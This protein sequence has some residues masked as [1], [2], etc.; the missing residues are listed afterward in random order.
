MMDTNASLVSQKN[1]IDHELVALRE[2][3]REDLN[4]IERLNQAN[5][6]R[7]AEGQ[8]LQGHVR[9]LEFDISKTLN[10]VEEMNRLIDQ[11]S[12]D[13]KQKEA[14][15]AETE[16]EIHNLKSQMNNF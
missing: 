1:H 14:E 2:R 11:K 12:Y 15:L 7:T 6:Q 10:K 8:D 3:N 9:A 4:E 13:Q 5:D 16:T